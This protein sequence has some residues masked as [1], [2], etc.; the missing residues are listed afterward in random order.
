MKP[1][2]AFLLLATTAAAATLLSGCSNEDDFD[3]RAWM[4]ETSK[5][6]KGRVAPLPAIRP[7]PA[8]AFVGGRGKPD[9]FSASRLAQDTRCEAANF[10][11]DCGR[12]APGM[13]KDR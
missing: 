2:T 3:R 1:A 6:I 9:P 11:R 12:A 13:P 10:A 4:A 5:G 8:I 7:N